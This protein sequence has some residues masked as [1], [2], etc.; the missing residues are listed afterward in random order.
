MNTSA[1]FSSFA[2]GR[3]GWGGGGGENR[4][5]FTALLNLD[6]VH[7]ICSKFGLILNSSTDNNTILYVLHVDYFNIGKVTTVF[8]Y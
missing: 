3:G 6:F 4:T 7:T 5:S 8:V 2:V 1:S